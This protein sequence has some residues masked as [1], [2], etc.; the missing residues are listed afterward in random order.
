MLFH[1]LPQLARR[2]ALLA[3]TWTILSTWLGRV[4]CG[5]GVG[6]GVLPRLVRG[7]SRS[8]K[9][10]D[11]REK[12]LARRCCC[13]LLVERGGGENG[14]LCSNKEEEGRGGSTS[15]E[16]ASTKAVPEMQTNV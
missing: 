8:G 12:T 11:P 5:G 1:I 9:Q 3:W 16:L 15:H 4:R 14:G 2:I 13:C 10:E 6:R 7:Q